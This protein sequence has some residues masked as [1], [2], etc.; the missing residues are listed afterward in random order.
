M[1]SETNSNSSL[2][3]QALKR[4][5][6]LKLLKNKRNTENKEKEQNYVLPK[7]VLFSYVEPIDK[8]YNES[9]RKLFAKYTLIAT[10]HKN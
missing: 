3:E 1:E 6:R 10:A 8:H 7:W 2:E 9:L 4:K 5:E